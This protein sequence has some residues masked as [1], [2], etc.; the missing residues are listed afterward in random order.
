MIDHA[1]DFASWEI[2]VTK[3][4]T[5]R[6]SK[7][8]WFLRENSIWEKS[9]GERKEFTIFK[10]LLWTQQSYTL[11]TISS[12]RLPVWWRFKCI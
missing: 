9:R 5:H 2:K 10:R 11:F 4:F 6:A 3:R 12:F 7:E 1:V 8:T